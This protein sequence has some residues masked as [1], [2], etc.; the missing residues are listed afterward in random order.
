MKMSSIRTDFP[1]NPV[2]ENSQGPDATGWQIIAYH[3]TCQMT[4]QFSTITIIL[5][6]ISGKN[7][8]ALSLLMLTKKYLNKSWPE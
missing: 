2:A 8:L 1:F 3:P 7:I 6:M 4:C 5:A